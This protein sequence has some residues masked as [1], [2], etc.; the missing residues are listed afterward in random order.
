[1]PR[2]KLI[3]PKRSWQVR[4]PEDLAARVLSDL[5]SEAES[6][7]PY[8]AWSTFVEL[9]IREHYARMENERRLIGTVE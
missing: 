2:T 1:M 8:G 3:N 4:L 6:C 5:F 9:C 7:V